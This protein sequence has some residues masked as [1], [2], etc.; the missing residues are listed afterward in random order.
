VAIPTADE[1]ATVIE[2]ESKFLFRLLLSPRRW[3]VTDRRSAF[4]ENPLDHVDGNP[5]DPRDL[6]SRHLF[7]REGT[8]CST[9]P[10]VPDVN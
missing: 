4:C 5:V 1:I 3:V 8:G 2:A 10:L 6:G 9:R 7:I